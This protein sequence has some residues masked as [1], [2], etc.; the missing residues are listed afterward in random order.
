MGHANNSAETPKICATVTDL[1]SDESWG[2]EG[3]VLVNEVD[4]ELKSDDNKGKVPTVT[5]TG[6]AIGDAGPDVIF[7]SDGED[8]VGKENFTARSYMVTPTC[9]QNSCF[10]N[11]SADGKQAASVVS[12]VADREQSETENRPIIINE[13]LC[14]SVKSEKERSPSKCD[15]AMHTQVPSKSSL[16]CSDSE[17][18]PNNSV[19]DTETPPKCSLQNSLSDDS[20][21][22]RTPDSE[23][24]LCSS[25]VSSE[26]TKKLTPKQLLKQLESARKKKEKERQRQVMYL[27]FELLKV[28][29]AYLLN[30][31]FLIAAVT[32]V[33]ELNVSSPWTGNYLS[34]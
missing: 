4:S 18:S 24:P 19:T 20:F 29:L 28:P 10:K 9:E 5:S 16:Q 14:G 2:V 30:L 34:V 33:L 32:L 15:S 31:T 11:E 25:L 26:K 1:D 8:S 21:R 3:E 22:E 23:T 7:L 27:K 12:P 17:I 6:S 13:C